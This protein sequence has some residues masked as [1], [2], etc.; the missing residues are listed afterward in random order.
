MAKISPPGHASLDKLEK[1]GISLSR[2]K[3]HDFQ[4]L[5]TPLLNSLYGTALR[6][7]KNTQ[8]AGSLVQNTIIKAFRDFD[9]YKVSEQFRILTFGILVNEY[10][11][12]YQ[13]TNRPPVDECKDDLEEFYLYQKV[14]TAFHSNDREKA[15]IL[16]SVGK[17]D[18]KHLLEK[19]PDQVRLP[20]I[21]SD[22]EGFSTSEIADIIDKSL[23]TVILRLALGRKL[24]QRYLWSHLRLNGFIGNELNTQE[25]FESPG[26]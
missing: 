23:P 10:F 6:M 16:N 8:K 4:E 22:V 20:V 21:L 25:N 15:D 1:K 26:N 7:T 14:D 9:Q 17:D 12:E 2:A 18:I 19:L 5:I 11:M 3:E 24:L 13:E